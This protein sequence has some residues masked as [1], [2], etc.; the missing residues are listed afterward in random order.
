M[1][2]NF[3]ID[4]NLLFDQV[5][6]KVKRMLSDEL[7]DEI[8]D[9]IKDEIFEGVSRSLAHQTN[10]IRREYLEHINYEFNKHISNAIEEIGQT[11]TNETMELM[12]K[13]IPVKY[14][15][16]GAIPKDKKDLI[17]SFY[18]GIAFAKAVWNGYEVTE[19]E[20]QKSRDLVIEKA[21]KNLARNIRMDYPKYKK[22]ADVL[23]KEME[24]TDAQDDNKQ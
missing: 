21:A 13:T 1:K 15:P 19:E 5:F 14:V 11:L 4:E 10:S 3:D 18:A 23:I 9:Q 7:K 16:G 17:R 8:K 22:L 12:G 6:D 2:L 24:A 20:A